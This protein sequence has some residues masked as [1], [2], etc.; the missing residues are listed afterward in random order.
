MADR[1]AH[2]DELADLH[3]DKAGPEPNVVL[4]GIQD[5]DLAIIEVVA[6]RAPRHRR[7]R[8]RASARDHGPARCRQSRRRANR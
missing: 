3:I 7:G 8:R 6:L 1:L 4:S 2:E 5:D